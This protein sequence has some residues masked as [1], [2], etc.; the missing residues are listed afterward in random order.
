MVHQKIEN[1]VPNN[2]SSLACFPTIPR[3]D[4]RSGIVEQLDLTIY[5][6][7]FLY[8]VR[9]RNLKSVESIYLTF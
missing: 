4:L 5:T 8:N 1:P 3:F 7:S 6:S 2:T 9:Q